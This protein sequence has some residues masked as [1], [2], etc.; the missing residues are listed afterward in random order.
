MSKTTDN[1]AP[2]DEEVILLEDL[3]PRDDVK[4]G[5]SKTVFGYGADFSESRKQL[6]IPNKR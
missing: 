1:E 5:S 4:A 6:P 3:L 2:R